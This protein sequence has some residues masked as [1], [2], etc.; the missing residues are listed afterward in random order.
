MTISL[1]STGKTLIETGKLHAYSLSIQFSGACA[2][3]LSEVWDNGLN[4]LSIAATQQPE[5]HYLNAIDL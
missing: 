2:T 3:F 4:C 1:Q 5:T